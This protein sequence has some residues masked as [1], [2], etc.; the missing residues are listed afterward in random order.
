MTRQTAAILAGTFIG[1]AIFASAFAPA[2]LRAQEYEREA[3]RATRQ[4]LRET[5]ATR[6]AEEARKRGEAEGDGE[7]TY[8]QVMADPDNLDLNYRYARSQVRRGDVKGAAATLERILLVN[9]DLHKARLFYA[10]VLYRLDNLAEAKGQFETLKAAMVPA[11][12][13]SE[14]ENYLKLISKRQK[15]TFLSGRLS[16]GFE[17]DDNRNSSPASGERL[18]LDVPVT[19]IGTAR[20]R[21]DTAILFLANIAARRDLGF[22]AGH[23]AFANYSFYMA[24]Q[25]DIKTLNLKAHSVRAGGVYKARWGNVTPTAIL[26]HVQLAQTTY[27]RTR[28]GS[29]RFDRKVSRRLI[30]FLEGRDVFQDYARTAVVPVAPERTGVQW[31]ASFGGDYQLNPTMRL[32]VSY[33]HTEKHASRAYNEFMRE[34]A[35]FSHSWLLGKGM[36]LIS[37][38]TL[39]WDRY[40][41]PDIVISRRYRRD[42]TIRANVTYGTPLA[43]IHKSLKDLVWTA[44]YEYYHAEST[45]RN[46]AYTNNKVATLLT[47]KWELGL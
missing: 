16:A 10:I 9:P 40:R 38:L 45:V 5:Q 22:Q 44:T 4:E 39:N 35:N 21:D 37:S 42:G 11:S 25:N 32:G 41:D 28:G 31:D 6:A 13:R 1:G 3:E 27:L 12:Y 7:V 24:E 14:A 47:Y 29:L 36:F 46:Y 18:F 20:R 33:A 2:P 8:E 34:S 17:F 26:D 30:L 19:L 23:E 15:K 43:F